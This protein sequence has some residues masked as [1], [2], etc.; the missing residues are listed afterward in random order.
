VLL[1]QEYDTGNIG[2]SLKVVIVPRQ[3]TIFPLAKH[4]MYH[5]LVLDA[6]D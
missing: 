4:E 1:K 2:V 3:K 6:F 5:L